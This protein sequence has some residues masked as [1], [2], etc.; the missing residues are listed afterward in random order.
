MKAVLLTLGCKV[1]QYETETIGEALKNLGYE[2]TTNLEEADIY[3]LN[4][5]AVTNEAERKSR[6]MIAKFNKLNPN[7]KI[8]VCGC[9]SQ[10]N[11]DQFKDLKNVFFVC[12]SANKLSI[13]EHLNKKGKKIDKFPDFYENVGISTSS[14]TR[15]YVKIQDGCNRF[16]SYCIIPYIRGRSRSRDILSI[17]K[18]VETLMQ[19]G[20]KEIVLSGIDISDFKIDD[21]PGILELLKQLEN[22]SIRVQLGSMEPTMITDEFVKT[23]KNLKNFCPHFHLS[24]QSGSTSVLKRMNRN[25]TSNDFVLAVKKIRKHF[26]NANITTD[27]IVGFPGETDKEFEETI[28]TI[29]KCKFAYMHIFPYSRRSGTTADKLLALKTNKAYFIV[30]GNIIK[31]RA[32]KLAKINEKN[33]RN[34][35]KKQIGKTLS[36]IV[37][38]KNGTFYVG[39]SEN[40]VKVFVDDL[41][42]MPYNIIRV[43]IKGRNKDGVI[44]GLL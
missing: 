35:N 13:L 26:K 22:Y 37:E 32:K 3:V 15:A 11:P 4:T 34:Y 10:N 43:K 41:K 14:N 2:T 20:V 9:A 7:A 25:Y 18:E 5:C 19:T 42:E 8:F 24:M 36:V 39:H 33:N 12:G 17:L 38:E 30:D 31:E 28:K 44:G 40:Y 6:Q 16:C 27:I 29:K 1:S 21:N 23:L